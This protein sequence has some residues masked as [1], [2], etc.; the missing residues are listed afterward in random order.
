MY[1]IW[2]FV[3][4]IGF[5]IFSEIL[6]YLLIYFKRNCWWIFSFCFSLIFKN[7][8]TNQNRCFNFVSHKLTI[9]DSYWPRFF[10]RFGVLFLSVF[11][12]YSCKKY[13]CSFLRQ[14][15]PHNFC[16]AKFLFI[17]LGSSLLCYFL[18]GGTR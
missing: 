16:F 5:D 18:F 15:F 17:K 9:F 1:L 12:F 10:C 6:A 7:K 11:T 3:D 4:Q 2:I 14:N 8:F 13:C